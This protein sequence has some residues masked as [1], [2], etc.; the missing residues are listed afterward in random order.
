MLRQWIFCSVGYHI[1]FVLS[2]MSL[3]MILLNNNLKIYSNW[4]RILRISIDCTKTYR[5]MLHTIQITYA[6]ER[7]DFILV[8]QQVKLVY[9]MQLVLYNTNGKGIERK[10]NG[11][12]CHVTKI[13]ALFCY[14]FGY[15]L[16]YHG[17]SIYSYTFFW[18]G[19][20]GVQNTTLF[21]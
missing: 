9:F 2:A 13:F 5:H 20:G 12:Y 3:R 18:G 11:A 19:G 8:L 4:V 7:R 6:F 16:L 10:L 14:E 1:I 21:T 17:A 15:N